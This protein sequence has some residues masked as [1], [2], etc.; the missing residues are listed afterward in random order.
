MANEN[1]GFIAIIVAVLAVVIAVIAFS[2]SG[3]AGANGL[4]G[5]NGTNGLNFNQTAPYTYLFN[6]TNG[7]NGINGI[8]GLNFNATAPYVYLF[9]GT[10]GIQ[11]IQG[12]QGLTG[13]TGAQGIQGIQGIQGLTGA[14]GATGVISASAPLIYNS[15]SQSLSFNQT[16]ENLAISITHSQISDWNLATSEFWSNYGYELDFLST[17]ISG[18]TE[19]ISTDDGVNLFNLT[20]LNLFGHGSALLWIDISSNLHISGNYYIGSTLVVNQALTSGSSP[21]FNGLTIG[22]TISISSSFPILYFNRAGVHGWSIFEYSDSSMYFQY[23]AATN[24]LILDSSG[25]L[26]LSGY[27]ASANY[28][29]G[30][31][32][33]LWG[34]LPSFPSAV[35]GNYFILWN[36]STS[37]GRIYCYVNGGWH[38]SS[39]T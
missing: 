3:V 2:N 5:T 17:A 8:N 33:A 36:T 18:H 25:D 15:G 12:I 16:N 37:T 11:G 28:L 38:Y 10:Q 39:L 30:A 22:S 32:G 29:S 24:A 35:N 13:A 14:T 27:M 31:Y 20:D 21:S 7:I 4:N 34:S 6:G 23:N 1:Y 26:T 9:N 19:L